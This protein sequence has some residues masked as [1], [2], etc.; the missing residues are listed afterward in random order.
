M[1]VW[2]LCAYRQRSNFGHFLQ[3]HHNNFRLKWEF[4]FKFGW[5]DRKDQYLDLYLGYQNIPYLNFKNTF[6]SIKI[7]VQ[8]RN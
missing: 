8:V 2:K 7:N 6:L 4:N 3:F 5:F 1:I